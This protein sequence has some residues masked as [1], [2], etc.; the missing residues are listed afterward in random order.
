MASNAG[1]WGTVGHRAAGEAHQPSS[2]PPGRHVEVE[3]GTL[4]VPGVLAR[5]VRTPAG[6]AGLCA[7]V[8]PESGELAAGLVPA[9][10][11]RD[12]SR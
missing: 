4:W 7:W 3:C 5:W 1:A 11:L 6:W 10:R 12:A 9:E 8:D 2:E